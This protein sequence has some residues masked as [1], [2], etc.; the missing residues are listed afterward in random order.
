MLLKH[1]YLEDRIL[2]TNLINKLLTLPSVSHYQQSVLIVPYFQ[3]DLSHSMELQYFL[4][5]I[6]LFLLFLLLLVFYNFL[7]YNQVLLRVFSGSNC[8]FVSVIFALLFFLH[9]IGKTLDLVEYFTAL[10]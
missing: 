3:V 6:F 4:S 1:S 5:L 7:F 10:I 2:K 8:M 9:I